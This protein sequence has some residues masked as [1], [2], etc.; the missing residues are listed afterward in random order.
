MT[1]VTFDV[2]ARDRASAVFSK[3]GASADQSTS[4]M[5][6]FHKVGAAAGVALAGGLALAG[7]A[8]F[9]MTK[10][11]AEDQQA[12]SRLAQTL[13]KAAGA[14]SDQVAQAEQWITAQGK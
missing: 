9:D 11:A 10:R 3:I 8:A 14:T 7:K 4:R 1:A 12:A 2:I 6:K 13:R 5:D